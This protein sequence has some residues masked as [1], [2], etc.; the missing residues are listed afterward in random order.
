MRASP[1]R[2]PGAL[3]FTLMGVGY[4]GILLWAEYRAPLR[5]RV[6]PGGRRLL[7]NAVM[8]A[9]AGLVV[10]IAER[11][12]VDPLAAHCERR[13]VGLTHFLPVRAGRTSGTFWRDLV[14]VMLMDYTLYLWHILLHRWDLLYR[15][16]QVHHSDLDLDVSTAVRFHFAEMLASVPW[17]LAQ[18]LVIGTSARALR[19]WQRAT[20]LS[21]LFHHSNIRLPVRLERLLRLFITTPRLHGIHHSLLREEQD[22][23]WSSGLTLWDFLHGTYRAD[24]AQEEIEIGVPRYRAREQV[25]LGKLLIMPR[26]PA[27]VARR[28]PNG[29]V[30]KR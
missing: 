29:R 13:R 27:A 25:T 5:P 30:P 23:N 24:P 11:P 1:S 7:R 19:I 10:Q 4:L 18:V 2:T 26:V 8:A 3:A 16:H 21:I 22:S 20:L 28:L 17:R 9:S 14:A 6:E 15:L 12:I